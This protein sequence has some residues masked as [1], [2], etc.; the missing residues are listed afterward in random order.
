[1]WGSSVK[2]EEL[3]DTVMCA[4]CLCT[5]APRLWRSILSLPCEKAPEGATVE[6]MRR[7]KK[8]CKGPA[9]SKRGKAPIVVKLD[10]SGPEAASS[11][12][13][14]QQNKPRVAKKRERLASSSARPPG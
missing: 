1:M 8:D 6:D 14:A 2:V 4:V 9:S 11:G 10:S 12:D 7:R 5:D 3:D 13:T